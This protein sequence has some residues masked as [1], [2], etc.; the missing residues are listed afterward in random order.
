MT[1]YNAV[2][3]EIKLY[4]EHFHPSG[5]IRFFNLHNVTFE[6]YTETFDIIQKEE[7]RRV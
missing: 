2:C 4:E 6:G 1:T 5:S 3:T 7:M